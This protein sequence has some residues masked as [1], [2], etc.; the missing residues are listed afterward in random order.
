[1]KGYHLLSITKGLLNKLPADQPKSQKSSEK[2]ASQSHSQEDS[3]FEIENKK[4]VSIV[5]VCGSCC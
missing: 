3:V 5:V 2:V 4:L 1:M